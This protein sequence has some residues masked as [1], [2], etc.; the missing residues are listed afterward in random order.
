MNIHVKP[1]P[2]GNVKLL[3]DR[4]E[5]ILRL[6]SRYACERF[7]YIA[8]HEPVLQAA[9]DINPSV[10]RCCLDRTRDYTLVEKALEYKCEKLQFFKPYF[11]REM[12]DS[13]HANGIRCNIFWSDDPHETQHF[14]EIGIDSILSNNMLVTAPVIRAYAKGNICKQ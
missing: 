10:A 7:S 4:V 9:L 14:L 13:A 2:D 6:L 12:I 3:Y 11:N 8:G 1:E 5:R